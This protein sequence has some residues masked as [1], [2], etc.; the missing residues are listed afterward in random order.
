M[1]ARPKTD[2]EREELSRKP[3]Q[4]RNRLRRANRKAQKTGD[5]TW[6]DAELGLYCE[7]TGMKPVTEWDVEELSHGRPRNENGSFSGAP[8]TW[9]TADVRQESKRR[10][11]DH[12]LGSLVSNVDKAVKTIIDLMLNDQVDEKGKPFVDNKTKFECAKFVIEYI[13]GKPTQIIGVDVTDQ[14]RKI[15]A[16]AIVLDNGQEDTHLVIEGT[17]TEDLDNGPDLELGSDEND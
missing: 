6:L 14:A 7:V 3:S 12:A 16:S 1:A 4:I 11:Y 8:P 9:L 15:L 2:K 10:L 17:A 13:L 5:R